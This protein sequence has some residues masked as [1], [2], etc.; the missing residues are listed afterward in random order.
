MSTEEVTPTSQ[1]SS[2]GRLMTALGGIAL[3]CGVLIVGAYQVTLT[4][5]AE[6]HRIALERS[7]FKLIPGGESMRVFAVSREGA[8]PAKAG[9]SLPKG[10]LPV[11]VVY[12][13]D[14]RIKGMASEGGAV[15][16]A[17]VVRVLYAYDVSRQ[18]VVNFSVVAH[19][20]TPGIGDK[21]GTDPAFRKN[22]DALD[23]QLNADGTA[24]V[25]PVKTVKHG[26]K[27]NAWEID[28]ISGATITSRA[29]GRG[30]NESAGQLLPALRANLKALEQP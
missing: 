30:I 13:A 2:G 6:N 15:G 29:I 17:D 26:T 28:A 18:L 20:E 27:R 23:V 24:L 5:I 22:F 4:P 14:K 19:R 25:N 3:I 11:Y 1:G 10:S 9:E 16:Y 21:P 8:K 7:V 12:D